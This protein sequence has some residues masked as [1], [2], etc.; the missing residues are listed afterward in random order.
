MTL[1]TKVVPPNLPIAKD[2]FTRLDEEYFRNVLR[3]YFN[4]L[5]QLVNNLAGGTGGQY[6]QFPYERSIK[7]GQQI[8]RAHV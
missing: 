7:T 4:Q 6:L 1:L 2:D 3:L 5:S 8:G